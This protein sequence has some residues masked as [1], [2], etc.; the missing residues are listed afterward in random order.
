MKLIGEIV[1]LHEDLASV[2]VYEETG[3]IGPGE[4]VLDTG[5]P[6]S[7]E[8]GPGLI[9]SIYDGIQRPLDSLHELEGEFMSRGS[10]LPGLDRQKKW[11]FKPTVKKG[12]KVGPGDIIGEVQETSM[13]LHRIM[14][15]PGVSGTISEIS[16]GDYTVTEPVG[17]CVGDDGQKKAG[18]CE[19]PGRWSAA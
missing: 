2:Q 8:L 10:S 13:V 12:D 4:T 5:A 15:P 7:V 19:R 9:E 1:E 16:Q 14:V 6:L 3:G 18:R 11:H 17:L